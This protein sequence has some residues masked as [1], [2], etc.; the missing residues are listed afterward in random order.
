MRSGITFQLSPEDRV[1]L[2]EIV[3]DRN[4]PQKHVWRAEIVLLSAA[5]TGTVEIMRRTGQSKPTVWR[6]QQRFMDEGVAGLLRDKTRP[7]GK[8]P[9]AAAVINQVLTKTATESPPDATH[10][11]ARAMA[12]AV[13]IS[14]RSVQRIWAGHGLKPHLMETFKVSNDPRFAEKLVDIVGLYLDPPDHALVLAVD[15]KSQI[16]A[17]D[18]TQ[19]GLPLKKGRAGT[20][21][22]D[23]KRNGTTTL[24]AA[25]N[26]LDGTVIGQCMDRHRH[27]E[28]IRFLGKVDH[29]TPVDLDLH[30]I[31]D[32][33]ATHKHPDVVKW[34]ERHPR[35]HLH[36]IPTSSSWLNLVERFFAE[37]TRKRI[38]RGI[39]KSVLDL[40][41]AI[42]RYL[43]EHNERPKPFV[44]TATAGQIL[45][46]VESARASLNATI[47]IKR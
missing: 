28:F 23:Y 35:F 34:L 2:E 41:V 20:M 43:A 45:E 33:Y 6:W 8:T 9:L 44:W 17:L 32:N 7:P 18:R 22:H 42:Y 16:Q 21:T 36:F 38:R 12:K 1:R 13:G 31:V 15:E 30:L 5:D 24:F 25:L 10:W 3:A 47:G 39:F 11:S 14:P 19:P 26:V 46:K 37:I 27:Q 29:D 40:E 4:T